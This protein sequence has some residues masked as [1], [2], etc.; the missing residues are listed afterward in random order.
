MVAIANFIKSLFVGSFAR[1]FSHS[2]FLMITFI[3][4]FAAFAFVITSL[5][6]AI[7]PSLPSNSFVAAG[8]SLIPDYAPIMLSAMWSAHVAVFTYKIKVKMLSKFK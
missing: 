3:G 8:F 6:N 5:L 1:K 2:S 7:Q 4:F